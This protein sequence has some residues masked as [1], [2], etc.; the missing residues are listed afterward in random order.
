MYLNVR[1]Y[2]QHLV[3]PFYS[4]PIRRQSFISLSLSL[5]LT[6]NLYFFQSLCLSILFSISLHISSQKVSLFYSFFITL[7]LSLPLS[8][9]HC[10]FV[11]FSF[12]T[13][14]STFK[15]EELKVIFFLV[16]V[17]VSVSFFKFL[18]NKVESCWSSL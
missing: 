13:L 6:L 9:A 3:C 11:N 16:C 7:S 15:L 2:L 17:F 14:L 4:V 1:F 18:S 10:S 5:S 12:L 8:V